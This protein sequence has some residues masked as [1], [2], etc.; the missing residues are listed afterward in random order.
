MGHGTLPPAAKNDF[1]SFPLRAKDIPATSI[2]TE[3]KAVVIR[4]SVCKMAIKGEISSAFQM[5]NYS[6][7]IRAKMVKTPA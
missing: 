2:S 6:P 1:I 3:N 5:V 7:Y 4:S